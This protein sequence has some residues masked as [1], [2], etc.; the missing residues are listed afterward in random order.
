MI[1]VR[2]RAPMV[3]GGVVLGCTTLALAACSGDGATATPAKASASPA[4]PA[5]ASAPS[6]PFQVTIANFALP[7]VT[8]PMGTTVVW[9]NKDSA[10]HTVTAGRNG[11]WDSKG[12]NSP[13]VAVGKS[14]SQAFTTVG[15]FPYTCRIHPSLNA[16][17]TVT[18]SGAP[19]ATTGDG[20]TGY[21]Y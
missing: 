11:Q 10:T 3:F 20:G 21:T 13:E 18:Q 14:F 2:L 7:N 19:S 15:T 9:A 8:V 17:V 6:S 16:T 4:P 1:L 12:W 5:S